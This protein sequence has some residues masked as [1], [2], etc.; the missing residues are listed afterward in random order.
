MIICSKCDLPKNED[1]FYDRG[2]GSGKKKSQCKLCNNAVKH[3]YYLKNSAKVRRNSKK[4]YKTNKT[5]RAKT[6]REYIDT[7][8]GRLIKLLKSAKNRAK[9]YNHTYELD[10][11]FMMEMWHKQNAKCTLTDFPFEFKNQT[12]Y[13][14]NP[15][16]PSIDRIDSTKGYT[17]DNVRI[18]CVAINYALNEFGESVFK[19]ICEA[20]LRKFDN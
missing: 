11:K 13:G 20:Y 4:W 16:A 15:F 10:T 3:N 12:K 8:K 2:D 5:R 18:V 17:K 19:T 1:E 9:R 14:S 7:P 6:A